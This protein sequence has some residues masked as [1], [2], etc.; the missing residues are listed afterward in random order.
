M[1]I[2]HVAESEIGMTGGMARV[3]WYWQQ[4]F[5][6][7]GHT[8]IHIG[9]ENVG[10]HKH[11][12]QFPKAALHYYKKIARAEDILLVHEPTAGKFARNAFETI[13]V[14]HGLE[15]RCWRLQ[16]GRKHLDSPKPSLKTRLLFPIWR[17][18]GCDHGLR[19]A[20][21]ALLINQEDKE[22]AE[23]YYGIKSDAILVFKNGVHWF[24]ESP[25]LSQENANNILF[26]GTWLARKGI[27]TLARVAENL[28]QRGLILNW[29]LAGTG[30]PAEQ[31]SQIWPASL[32]ACTKIIRKFSEKEETELYRQ[33]NLFVLPSFFEGQPLSLLQA[34]AHVRCCITTN[35]C[36]QKDIIKHRHNGLM[37]E[38]GDAST[39]AD[40]IA[41]A[42]Q[43][44]PL[45]T[46]LGDNAR[47]SITGR[48]WD[49][50]ASE[51]VDFVEQIH[52]KRQRV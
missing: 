34:M 22:F 1:R 40:L 27:H 28:H 3:G 32:S 35:V 48:H 46:N 6:K 33:C 49:A 19:H 41:E 38:P 14:S 17:L 26:S 51:V 12:R 21:G 20:C 9:R 50:A 43:D 18:R 39:L 24:P 10:A 44:L 4:A 45:Q 37:F 5:E 47:R 8:F 7:R 30:L 2:V 36:G 16:T 52:L 23:S 11:I 29:I 15:R 13:V 42:T 25:P 31:V